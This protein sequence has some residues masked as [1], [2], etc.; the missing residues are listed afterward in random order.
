[1]NY[2]DDSE[3]SMAGRHRRHTRSIAKRVSSFGSKLAAGNR[4]SRRGGRWRRLRRK[5]QQEGGRE[6]A[7]MDDMGGGEGMADEL[8]RY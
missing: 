8:F 7:K 2:D 3:A 1:M 6:Q 4:K 5:Q